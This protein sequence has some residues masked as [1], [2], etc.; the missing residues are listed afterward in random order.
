MQVGTYPTRDYATLEPSGLG[1]TFTGAYTGAYA[2][3]ESEGVSTPVLNLP[4]LV[5][6]HP[7]Y[8]PSSGLQGAVFLINSRQANLRCGVK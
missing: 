6:L 3:S 2:P 4:A 5:R 1:L 7:L 8:V